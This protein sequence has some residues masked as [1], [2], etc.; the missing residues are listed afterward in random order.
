[1]IE[2]APGEGVPA[3][4]TTAD[5]LKELRRRTEEVVGHGSARAAERQHPRGR[6]TARERIE[7]LLDPGSFVELDAFV[8][9]RS[10]N[11]GLERNRPP[12]DG[13]VTGYGTVDG[14]PICLYSQDASVFG[15]SLGE[16]HGGK[17]V[18]VM[19]LA[20][21]TGRPIVGI[22]D[23]AGGRLQEGVV[24][25][26]IYGEIFRRNVRTSGI[27]PQIS[28]ILGSCAGGACYS[29]ALTDFVVMV[30]GNS[31]M[32]LTG[33]DVIRGATGEQVGLEELSGG[34]TNNTRSGN[35]HYLGAGDEDA[36]GYVQ[37]LLSYLPSNNLADPP[38]YAPGGV[39][40]AAADLDR[41]VPDLAT[42]PY[43]MRDVLRSVVDDGELDE[44]Q[45]LYAPNVIVGFA[46]IE[47]QSVGV[48]ANQP[49][50]LAGCLD[51]NASEKAARFVRTCDAFN[52]PIV[53]LVDVP[54][55][56][57]G[58][59]QEWNGII[60][61]GAK[62]IY[63]YAEASVPLVTVVIRKAYGGAYDVMG[64]K[65]LGADLNFAWPTAQIAVMGAA[66]ATDVLYRKTIA[67]AARQS[68]DVDALRAKLAREYEETLLTP[69][70]AAEHG[71][72]DAVIQPSQTRD[73]V[74]T[75][76][77][78]LKGKRDLRLPR[79]HGNIPL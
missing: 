10:V 9:H 57:P 37:Q 17:I 39:P 50:K 66:N 53:T 28:L 12:G 61:R 76:L 21:R 15:G 23:G 6:L 29:P 25:Q 16:A 33:P 48:V 31:H 63:A 71:Y 19:D 3:P 1:M 65:H 56:L 77:K 64:S 70:L 58:T 20:V 44:V 22:N 13:V 36:I 46:R 47:G 75:A 51:I 74:A 41:L 79:K 55:F 54:G 69:Y 35:A 62:L 40:A 5:R 67:E 4:T 30:D 11:F 26:A 7:L 34:L 72:I 42:Q 2:P 60:R 52:V 59:E 38:A 78:G 14:R 68:A 18:K 8:R 24:A 27:V 45:E 43:D 32:F 73:H 49:A